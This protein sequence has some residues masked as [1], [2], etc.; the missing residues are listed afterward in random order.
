MSISSQ[1]FE[2]QKAQKT[3]EFDKILLEVVLKVLDSPSGDGIVL[4]FQGNALL[5]LV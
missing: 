5:E 3:Q 1:D 4:L 2:L